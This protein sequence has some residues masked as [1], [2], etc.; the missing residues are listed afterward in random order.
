MAVPAAALV[1]GA[2]T[3]AGAGINAAAQ[4]KINKRTERYNKWAMDQQ[5]QWALA[6]WERQNQYNSPAQQ[7][8]RLRE[9]GLNP[10]LIYGGGQ[11]TNT[12]SAVQG[13]N[14]NPW[15]PKAPDL[16]A[17]LTDP[18]NAYMEARSFQA[19][20]K[21]IDAQTL[22]VLSDVDTKNFDLSQKERLA[23]T[24][25]SIMQEILTGKK[26]E[27]ELNRDENIRR[28]LT[29][30]SNLTEAV[31]RS[32]KTVTDTELNKMVLQKGNEEINSIQQMRKKVDQEID[33]LKKEGKIKD[34]E[35]Q[36]N[37]LGFTKSDPV[38]FRLGKIVIDKLLGQDVSKE[39]EDILKN[40]GEKAQGIK[41]AL[42]SIF[43]WNFWLGESA[44]KFFNIK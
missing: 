39:L 29:T 19:Q 44:Q 20:Q 9:A 25:A 7:M 6:D 26:V 33:N 22:K 10:H 2:A 24:Q 37:K 28:N 27:N 8:Q 11:P 34:F 18:V 35:I 30:S 42:S 15:N 43:S 16:G 21:L 40:S 32:A 1:A 23:D 13:T 17:I 41:K 5:R 31:I 14:I 38:Y 12:A 3:V 36:L 4:G